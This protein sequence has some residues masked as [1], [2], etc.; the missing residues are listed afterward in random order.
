MLRD[1]T[2]EAR[3]RHLS[4]ELRCLVC[5]NQSIDDSNAP[6]ARDLRLLLRERLTAG[7]TDNEVLA[8]LTA[9]YGDFVLLRPPF[10]ARTVVLWLG[11]FLLL[12]GA[13]LLLLLRARARLQQLRGAMPAPLSQAE[14]ERLDQLL[15]E[16]PPPS[17]L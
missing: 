16:H 11:P 2:L 13:G 12:T 5:Q 10:A 17:G 3:A 6:L 9:R 8:F 14:R 7:D 4:Q 1:P 15:Q